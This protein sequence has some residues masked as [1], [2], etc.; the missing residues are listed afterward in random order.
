[1]AKS[2]R[3]SRRRFIL[4]SLGAVGALAVGWAAWPSRQRLVP[5]KPLT[6]QP[7]QVA[8][9]GWVKV[10][11]D[12]TIT[13]MLA[14]AEMGQGAST[15]LAALLADEMDAD[16]AQVKFEQAGYDG[17]YNN[18]AMILE[19]NGMYLEEDQGLAKRAS[20]HVLSRVLREVPG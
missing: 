4:G 6:Q 19:N 9:N 12:N 14:A 20:L 13:L 11:A 3:K 2:K 8:L 16:L 5:G 18:Q 10:G 17:I 15:G 7:G 1:M